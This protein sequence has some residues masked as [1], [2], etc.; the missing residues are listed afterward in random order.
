MRFVVLLALLCRQAVSYAQAQPDALTA[1]VAL[2]TAGLLESLKTLKFNV[3]EQFEVVTV[4]FNHEDT[5]RHT[6][7]PHAGSISICEVRYAF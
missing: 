7:G 3:G 5:P 2:G 6:L 4:S 1:P